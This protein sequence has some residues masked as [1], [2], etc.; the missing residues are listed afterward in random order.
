MNHYIDILI[1][2]N[3]E[4]SEPVLMSDLLSRLHRALLKRGQDP[5]PDSGIVALE[6]SEHIAISFPDYR[7]TLGNRLRLH[8]TQAAL[9]QLEA[10]AW[11]RSFSG[12]CQLTEMTAIPEV[13]RWLRVQRQREGLSAAKLRRLAK[14]AN[15][16]VNAENLKEIQARKGI[17][18]TPFA[19]LKSTST[20]Q[21]FR[22]AIV[23]QRAN[24][25][26]SGGFNSFGLSKNGA[27]IPLF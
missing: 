3:P 2:A 25:A 14:R 13:H 19:G 15:G 12:S 17:I 5:K 16:A 18:N 24:E 21:G 7:I 1:Q 23:Q 9:T 10:S 8:G 4:I 22:L 20:G 6:G 26:G 11:R 27:C